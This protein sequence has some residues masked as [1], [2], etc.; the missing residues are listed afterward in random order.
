VLIFPEGTS[1]TDR[2]VVPLK[3]G[4]ARLALGQERRPG[5]QL[6]KGDDRRLVGR[7]CHGH[8]HGHR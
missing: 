2:Q 5:Q 8:Q 4:A 1:L 7:P 6:E 3:T